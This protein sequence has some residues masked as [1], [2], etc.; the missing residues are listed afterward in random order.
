MRPMPP[1]D[2][3]A[4]PPLPEKKISYPE[5]LVTRTAAVLPPGAQKAELEHKGSAGH[6]QAMLIATMIELALNPPGP[7]SD[8]AKAHQEKLAAE[9][10]SKDQPSASKP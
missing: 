7:M 3:K 1:H 10:A 8:K 2:P 9:A 4:A 5:Q 6:S